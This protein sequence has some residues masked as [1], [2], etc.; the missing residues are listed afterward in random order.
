MARTLF[1][2][3]GE[4]RGH[5]SQSVALKEYLEE[6]GH[7]VEAVYLG[8]SPSREIP[9]YYR[10]IFK[11]KLNLFSS[12]WFLR[13]PNHKGIYVGRTI[14]YNLARSLAYLGEVRRLRREI[15]DLKPEVV[16]NF[17]DLIGA[18]ALRKLSPGIRRMGIGHHF[19][20]HL[21]G[22]R[23]R[24]GKFF[25]K[26]L[27][28]LHSRIIMKSCDRVLALSFREVPGNEKIH[29]VPPLVRQQF[30]EARYKKGSDYLVYLL[31]TGFVVDLIRLVR[32]RP[33]LRFDL[34]SDLPL[35]TPVP[36]G[37][38]LHRPDDHAFIE[39][40]KHCR[41]VITTAGFDTAAE[42]AYM[43]IPL[44]VIPLENHYEQL[45]NSEDV[46]RSGVGIILKDFS[47]ASLAEME[48]T[49]NTSYRSWV[50]GSGIQILKHVT[51]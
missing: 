26:I 36:E 27:L 18:L 8:S 44:A 34:F 19:F 20:L 49:D 43:G 42:A 15:N 6:E 21:D 33:D 2:V 14:L 35:Q 23:C 32:S 30:R 13:T 38:K 40:M 29:V 17:Y 50:Q 41:G 28:K 4:G 1:I 31:H 9:A 24:R 25:H 7:T 10:N 37:I 16:F 46:V 22:Y 45:C 47:A 12:P 3:Q 48:E 11:D 51:G 39:K 5:L